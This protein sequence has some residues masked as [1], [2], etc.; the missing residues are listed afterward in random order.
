MYRRMRPNKDDSGLP[1]NSIGRYLTN[2]ENPMATAYI[3][4]VKNRL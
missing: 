4:T 3:P 2:L 1:L